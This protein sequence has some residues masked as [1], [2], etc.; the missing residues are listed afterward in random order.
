MDRMNKSDRYR[1]ILQQIIESQAQ[2]PRRKDQAELVPV[3]DPVH[4]NYLLMRVGWDRVGRAHNVLIHFRLRDGKVWIE[5][6]GIEH[7]IANDLI[8][9]GIP[10]EDI[11]MAFYSREPKPLAELIA[12]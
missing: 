4:D 3:C 12:A 10:E 1:V 5:Q 9:V 6:D 7:G 11:V 2:A 8:N